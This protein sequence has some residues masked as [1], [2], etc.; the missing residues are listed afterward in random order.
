LYTG[1]DAVPAKTL[2]V[3]MR[4]PTDDDARKFVG[5]ATSGFQIPCMRMGSVVH[6]VLIADQ[7][8]PVVS[9]CKR[10]SGSVE[11]IY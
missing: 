2:S 4:F 11:D 7:L 5:R 8:E 3:T 1:K 6:V 10:H 9:I